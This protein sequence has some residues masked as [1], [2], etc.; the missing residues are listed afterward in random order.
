MAPASHSSSPSD[1]EEME[2]K[3][4]VN[5]KSINAMFAR[6]LTDA[7]NF[8]EYM[9]ERMDRQDRVLDELRGQVPMLRREMDDKVAPIYNR[10]VPIEAARNKENGRWIGITFVLVPLSALLAVA[11]DHLLKHL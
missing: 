4:A 9:R 2:V 6:V 10:L 3:V 7:G 8:K 5:L 11:M 1:S